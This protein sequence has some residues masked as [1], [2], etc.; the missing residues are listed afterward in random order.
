M[1]TR[2]PVFSRLSVKRENARILPSLPV[3][4]YPAGGRF[5]AR[6]SEFKVS[7]KQGM[8]RIGDLPRVSRG[9]NVVRIGI[10][11][12]LSRGGAACGFPALKPVGLFF[13]ETGGF[14][15]RG[16]ELKRHSMKKP[17]RE[18]GSLFPAAFVPLSIDCHSLTHSG[19]SV[20]EERTAGRFLIREPGSLRTAGTNFKSVFEF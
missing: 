5:H 2:I 18:A 16:M 12:P 4:P 14:L 9:E 3:P 10:R 20:E 13:K 15:P 17:P 11:W 8:A 6:T 7:G 19:K 1:L